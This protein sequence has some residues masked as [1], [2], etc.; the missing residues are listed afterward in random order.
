MSNYEDLSILISVISAVVALWAIVVSR[1]TAEEQKNIAHRTQVLE[2]RNLIATHHGKYSDL[3][4]SV[5]S[6][7]KQ[8]AEELSE[9]AYSA[10]DELI[11]LFD[12]FGVIPT[13]RE[14][15]PRQTRHI[16]YK[17]CERLY[18]SFNPHLT[19]R[20]G[21]NL[22]GRFYALRD[23]D[24]KELSESEVERL[25]REAKAE[26][27]QLE[28]ACREDSNEELENRVIE[29]YEFRMNVQKLLSR[30]SIK[31]RPI[32]FQEAL[33]KLVPFIATYESGKEVL[34]LAQK[35]LED[36]LAQNELEEFSLKESPE[37]LE[38]YKQELA[39]LEILQNLDL[40]CVSCMADM[41]VKNSIPELIFVGTMLYTISMYSSW[42]QG[43]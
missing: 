3:L 8:Y 30:I 10:L 21:M 25:E 42:G 6:Q 28:K 43:R 35:K 36:G 12:K 9:A 2:S 15:H 39:K 37:L 27:I 13:S 34:A 5:Q 16:F 33:Q 38:A 23:I 32:I 22:R 29:S 4:F 1:T 19:S 40:T 18:Q 24:G 26:D 11:R 31:D 17:E 7:T 14:L 20:N 41:Q